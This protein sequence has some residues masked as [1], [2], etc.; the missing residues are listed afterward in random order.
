MWK[1]VL[2]EAEEQEEEAGGKPLTTRSLSCRQKV[3]SLL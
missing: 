3:A 2:V 1:M